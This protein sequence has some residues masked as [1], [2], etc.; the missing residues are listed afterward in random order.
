MPRCGA[1]SKPNVTS[2]RGVRS[3]NAAIGLGRIL[4]SRCEL[5]RAGQPVSVPQPD[6]R[7]DSV[8]V[9]EGEQQQVP[10][11]EDSPHLV[12]DELVLRRDRE[13]PGPALERADGGVHRGQP[14]LRRG[15][16]GD[17]IDDEPR[18]RLDG[19]PGRG[20]H[21]DP[22]LGPSPSVS[23]SSLAS[24]SSAGRIACTRPVRWSSLLRSSSARLS[25]SSAF[26]A[27]SS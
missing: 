12:L 25:A 6:H 5:R 21:L 19:A 1:G 27:S 14:T 2:D 22:V 9:V 20:G 4:R 11:H 3:W 13:S 24:C 7:H 17:L 26:S 15:A 23:P 8:L 16:I 10:A 18:V